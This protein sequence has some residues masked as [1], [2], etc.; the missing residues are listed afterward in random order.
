MS[1]T[2]KTRYKTGEICV[3]AGDYCFD[4]YTDGTQTPSPTPEER[5]IPLDVNDTF[6]PIRSCEK[7]CYWRFQS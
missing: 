2:T 6:P 3:L 7:A 1:T 5:V 4:G